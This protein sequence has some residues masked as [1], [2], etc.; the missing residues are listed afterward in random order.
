MANAFHFQNADTVLKDKKIVKEMTDKI[1]S[2]TQ[3]RGLRGG[4]LDLSEYSEDRPRD[5]DSPGGPSGSSQMSGLPANLAHGPPPH[6]NTRY[7]TGTVPA[8]ND[9]ICKHA[10]FLLVHCALNCRQL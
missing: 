9:H 7:A 6:R 5:S 10:L 1:K 8:P 3:R 2:W 4:F